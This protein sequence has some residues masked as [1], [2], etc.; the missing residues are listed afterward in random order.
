MI[1]V[2][3]L[4]TQHYRVLSAEILTADVPEDFERRGGSAYDQAGRLRY[5]NRQGAEGDRPLEPK[6]LAFRK[7]GDICLV[8]SDDQDDGSGLTH[9]LLARVEGRL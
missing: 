1:A 7:P 4:S 3:F 5:P 2:Q 8:R 6:K 9:W